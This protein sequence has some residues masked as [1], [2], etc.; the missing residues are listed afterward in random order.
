MIFQTFPRATVDQDRAQIDAAIARVL[1]SGSYI[2]GAE[3]DTFEQAFADY[4]GVGYGIGVANGTDAVELALRG[5]GVGVGDIVATVSH[6]A[7]ATAAAIVACGAEPAWVDIADG[8]FV[9]D[10]AHLDERVTALRAGPDGTRLKA[11]VAVHLYGDMVPPEA[12]LD[13]CRRHGLKLIED[14]A[15]AHGAAWRGKRA[16]S[17]GD[18][19]AF[20]FYPT[21]NLGAVGDGGMVVTADADVAERVR[22][23]RQYG[24]K[25]R[26]VSHEVGTNS[27]LDPLQ[28]AILG[29]MLGRLDERNDH[30]R[31]VAAAYDAVLA[32]APGVAT[33]TAGPEVHHVYHQYVVRTTARDA[34]AAHLKEK[35]VG[36]AIHYPM[37]VHRQPAY[38]GRFGPEHLPVTDRTVPEILSLPM[39]PQLSPDDAERIGRIVREVSA[40]TP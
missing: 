35:G 6:T 37:P 22:L 9:M 11:I 10:T 12:L 38:A 39:H 16:G 25:E 1:D 30:R 19:A 2:L 28:A 5:I 34:L 24:W 20:S 26:Y 21:K 7:V 36:T 18:A 14:C 40:A 23:L 17:F 31:A 29:V 32:D 4:I 3:V 8:G 33:P 13:V 15:Q 27:R